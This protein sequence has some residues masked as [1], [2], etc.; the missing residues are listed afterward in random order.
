MKGTVDIFPD[1]RQ[2]YR[3]V[4]AY[5]VQLDL[6]WQSRELDLMLHADMLSR[7]EDSLRSALKYSCSGP[8]LRE[9]V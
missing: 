8:C 9:Y 6:I 5:Y 7:L 2:L 1:V 3:F 4:A